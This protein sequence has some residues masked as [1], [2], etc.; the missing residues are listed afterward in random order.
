MPGICAG[1]GETKVGTLLVGDICWE[2]QAGKW[3]DDGFKIEHYDVGMDPELR[4]MISQFIEEDPK[5]LRLKSGLLEDAIVF[6][7]I[8][9]APLSTG[10]AVIADKSRMEAIAEQH[11]KMAGLDMELY[12]VYQAAALSSLR[13]AVFG[14]KTVVDGGDG[15]KSDAYHEYGCALSARF[16]V[17][18]VTKFFSVA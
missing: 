6:E 8:K 9:I 15:N 4:T 10:S 7:R 14:V 5:G 1:A 12:G 16:V 3:S 13:P 11:R 18:V 2:Y 17:A